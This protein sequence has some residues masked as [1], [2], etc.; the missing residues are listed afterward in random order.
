PIVDKKL[1]P[2]LS[3]PEKSQ[4]EDA[5]SSLKKELL[6]SFCESFPEED[7]INALESRVRSEIRG[8]L[9]D[10]GKRIDDMGRVNLSRR[11]LFEKQSGAPGARPQGAPSKDYPF[12]TQRDSRPPRNKG[13]FHNRGPDRGRRR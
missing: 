10:K 3:Q 1:A 13:G 4:R 7:I 12:R 6:E 2:A 11:A 9:L 5:L 8:N